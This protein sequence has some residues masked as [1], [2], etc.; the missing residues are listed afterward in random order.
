MQRMSM[1]ELAATLGESVHTCR[2]LAGEFALFIP[3]TRVGEECFFRPEAV[4]ILRL[5]LAQL[6]VGVRKDYIDTML[7]RR[8]PVAEVSIM[9]V[10]G[11]TSPAPIAMI[12]DGRGPSSPDAEAADTAPERAPV[13]VE[14][15]PLTLNA[16]DLMVTR[17]L[18]DLAS[19]V[20]ALTAQVVALLD[21][22]P[23]ADEP[24]PPA[25]QAHEHAVSALGAPA[26]GFDRLRTRGMPLASDTAR[27][28]RG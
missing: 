3:A 8:Y 26:R 2:V 9:M 16:T 14:T 13:S 4:E 7:S 23:R 24:V 17:R 20:E 28:S 11:S 6:E 18:D 15:D 25:S 21:T 10:A 22:R 27:T 1:N 19:Q 12:T 5:I